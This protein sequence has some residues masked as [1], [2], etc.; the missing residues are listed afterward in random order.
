MFLF[1]LMIETKAKKIFMDK[2]DILQKK[3]KKIISSS[4]KTSSEMVGYPRR[5]P[6][7]STKSCLE[8]E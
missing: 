4:S 2:D 8:T 1:V 7:K 5:R 3:K 6:S